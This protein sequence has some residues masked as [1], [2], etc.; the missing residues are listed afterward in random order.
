MTS[1]TLITTPYPHTP[2]TDSTVSST[3]PRYT[4]AISSMTRLRLS[5]SLSYPQSHPPTVV[6]AYTPTYLRTTR[7]PAYS[8]V[9]TGPVQNRLIAANH[10]KG[11]HVSAATSQLPTTKKYTRN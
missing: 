10:P 8:L 4:Q 1:Q 11:G 3:V 9:E 7:T 6:Y 2:G 5:D